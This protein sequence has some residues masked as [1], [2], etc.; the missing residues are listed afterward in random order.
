M[1]R[2]AREELAALERE[3]RQEAAA[4]ERRQAAAARQ[5]GDRSQRA[6]PRPPGSSL[7]ATGAARVIR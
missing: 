3:D 6:A 1:A 2:S 7:D 5:R 4:E